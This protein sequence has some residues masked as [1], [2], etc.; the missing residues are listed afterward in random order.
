MMLKKYIVTGANPFQL[1]PGVSPWID[2]GGGFIEADLDPKREEYLIQAGCIK[3][4]PRKDL[5]RSAPTP[6][7][8]T[9]LNKEKE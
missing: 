7:N 6:S 8:V 2:P 5:I 3:E 9:E 4:M 1:E